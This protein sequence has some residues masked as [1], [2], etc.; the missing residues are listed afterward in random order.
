M[1]FTMSSGA[2]RFSRGA[3]AGRGSTSAA[4][5]GREPALDAIR[6]SRIADGLVSITLQPGAHITN[7]FRSKIREQ[8]I[9]AFD[10][11]PAGVMLNLAGV[12]FIDR[13]AMIPGTPSVT[14]TALALLG[15]NA[16]DR[17][18]AHRLL[19]LASPQCPTGYFT[20]TQ[21][22]LDWLRSHGPAGVSCR[23]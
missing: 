11:Q 2:E 13:E 22:A 4:E 14:V 19:G 21:E 5:L 6:I 20:H 7:A 12:A 16:V 23:A 3:A 18:V 15:Q 10:G 9:A 1:S 8:V 17:V